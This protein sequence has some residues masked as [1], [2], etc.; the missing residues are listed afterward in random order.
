MAKA[1]KTDVHGKE[2][3]RKQSLEI[4]SLFADAIRVAI[5]KKQ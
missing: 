2:Q 4:H 5:E 3:P 1:K